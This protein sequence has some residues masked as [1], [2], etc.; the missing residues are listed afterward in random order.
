MINEQNPPGIWQEK[1]VG[2]PWEPPMYLNTFANSGIGAAVYAD[3]DYYGQVSF[4]FEIHYWG[5]RNPWGMRQIKSRYY[6]TRQEAVDAADA[7]LRAFNHAER[8]K[9][10]GVNVD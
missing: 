7:L 2:V 5:C 3:Y 10:G 8:E 1:P 6:K 4:L 9:E